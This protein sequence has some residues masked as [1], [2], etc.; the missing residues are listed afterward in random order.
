[1]SKTLR[2]EDIQL[3]LAKLMRPD[4]SP[5]QVLKDARKAHPE[6]SKSD[7]IRGAFALMIAL[8]EKDPEAAVMLQDFAITQRKAQD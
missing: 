7:I 3:T 8:A 2:S 4:A 6:A 1:M 5:K